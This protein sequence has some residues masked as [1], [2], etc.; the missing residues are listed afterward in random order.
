MV[1]AEFQ[2]PDT[3]QVHSIWIPV[4]HLSDLH[5]PLPPRAIGY[6][7]STL[8]GNFDNSVSKI[9]SIYARQT[10][11]QFFLAFQHLHE[12]AV[13]EEIFNFPSQQMQLQEIISWSL[14]EE[15]SSNTVTGWMNEL[16]CSIPFA[17]NKA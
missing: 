16:T 7:I 17:D 6:T 1:L 13:K 8:K 2:D 11:I 3:M 12:E 9:E 5:N 4:S 14:W 15:F 10:L